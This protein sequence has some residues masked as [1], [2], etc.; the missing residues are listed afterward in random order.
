[1]RK[2]WISRIGAG[3]REYDLKYGLFMHGL[4]SDNI[5][6]NRKSLAELA[7]S[8]PFSFKALVDRVKQLRSE[9]AR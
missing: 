8:E 6:L 1:M 5:G 3:A 2:L 4:A 7:L 9:S